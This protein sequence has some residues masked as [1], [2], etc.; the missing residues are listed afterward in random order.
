DPAPS[1]F[2]SA[3]KVRGISERF[4][5]I[6]LSWLECQRPPIIAV[7]KARHTANTT[8]YVPR[9]GADAFG[10]NLARAAQKRDPKNF[11]PQLFD[12]KIPVVYVWT[13]DTD[14]GHA[15]TVTRLAELLYQFGRGVDMAYAAAEVIDA[16]EAERRLKEYEGLIYRPTP[17]GAGLTLRCPRKNLSLD[18]L[19]KRH[20]AQLVRLKDGN[21]RQAPPA[22][23][24]EVGYGCPPSRFLYDIRENGSD[25]LFS[26]QPLAT[27]AGFAE[28]LRDHAA[29]RLQPHH[30]KLVE[31]IVIGRGASEADKALRIR[32]IPLPSIGHAQTNQDV[33]RVLVE[34]PPNCPIPV[35]DIRW[36]FSGLN[37]GTDPVSGEILSEAGP[38]LIPAVDTRMLWHYG[39]GAEGAH[40]SRTWRTVT[41]V[42]LP[43]PR[44]RG[45]RNGS[46]HALTAA[47][48]S[49]AAV[50][51][52]RHAGLEGKATVRRVQRESFDARG[53]CAKSFAHGARFTPDRLHHLEIE[54]TNPVP[55]PILIGDGR[56]YGLG[57]LR[58]VRDS[59]RD[60][61]VL[62]LSSGNLPSISE[63]SGFVEAVRRSLMALDR[64]LSGTVSRLFSGHEPDG[65]AAHSGRHDHVFL[66]ADDNDGDGLIDQLLVIAPWR[67]DRRVKPSQSDRRAFER[68]TT[69]LETVRAGRLG[70]FEFGAAKELSEDNPFAQRSRD[71][72]SVSPYV[73]TRFP[74]RQESEPAALAEDM[75]LECLRRALPNPDV[76]ILDVLAGP[77][78]GV[79]AFARL[80]FAVAVPGPIL[81]GRDSHAG[82]GLFRAEPG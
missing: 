40:R 77:R 63:R 28:A 5:T 10:G 22:I 20:A 24:D 60:A 44:S 36:A 58:P 54:F 35:A 64:D 65:S 82:G 27:I 7:P 81:L 48:V 15:D 32:I 71:W 61:V 30:P 73:P 17:G 59:I 57:F 66:A 2:G 38:V 34:V 79:R 14:D 9:N 78:G 33:R 31:K 49:F 8:Y 25:S 29:H 12:Q 4:F 70:V 68:V 55:G 80:K 6:L 3:G 43:V 74:K 47:A 23:F 52:L 21:F 75:R 39:I 56:Y 51:A 50:E 41:P 11:R 18:S 37:L 53:E 16:G 69:G 72:V 76:E 1:R 62:P 19:L 13:F 46:E 67:V 45:Q 26:P 42:V